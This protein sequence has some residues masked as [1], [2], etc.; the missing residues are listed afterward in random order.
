MEEDEKDSGG[1]VELEEAGELSPPTARLRTSPGNGSPTC[2]SCPD[3]RL[4]K[5]HVQLS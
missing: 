5:G 1:N 2:A 4:W 3:V